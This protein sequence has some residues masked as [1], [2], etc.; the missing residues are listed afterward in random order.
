M[1]TISCSGNRSKI[2]EAKQMKIFKQI[3]LVLEI[4]FHIHMHILFK[5]SRK[6]FEPFFKF[7]K[8]KAS[9]SNYNFRCCIQSKLVQSTL[10]SNF[11]ILFCPFFVFLIIKQTWMF[12]HLPERM[13]CVF[14]SLCVLKLVSILYRCEISTLHSWVEELDCRS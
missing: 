11:S 14:W 4:V 5:I 1:K 2:T 10:K 6:V 3:G 7:D 12:W 8:P 13:E 9:C